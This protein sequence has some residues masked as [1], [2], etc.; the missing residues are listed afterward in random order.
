MPITTSCS[1]GRKLNLKDELAGKTVKCPQCGAAL[2]VPDGKST[3][4][5]VATPPPRSAPAD[6]KI[7]EKPSAPAKKKDDAGPKIVMSNFK[8]LEDF[9]DAGNLKKKKKTFTKEEEAASEVGTSGGEMAK[10][11]AE[12]LTAE[13]NKP[14]HRCP[15]CGKGVKPDDVI[16]IKCGTNIKT[17]RRLGESAF[18]L[19]RR[20]ML[21]VVGI[22]A[23]SAAGAF[24][25][26]TKI[27]PPPPGRA[28]EE[29]VKQEQ[30]EIEDTLA[31]LKEIVED[32][33]A[34][35]SRALAHVANTGADALPVLSAAVRNGSP[36]A[37]RKAV[38]LMEMLAY[39]GYRT[40]ES[41]RALG[42]LARDP[43]TT[44]KEWAAEAL[45]WSAWD[46]PQGQQY[47]PASE[48][49]PGKKT[50]VSKM[51]LLPFNVCRQMLAD[52][53]VAVKKN[54]KIGKI[55]HSDNMP[56]RTAVVPLAGYKLQK[57]YEAETMQSTKLTRLI[58][59]V[60]A[61]RKH[62]IERL[63]WYVEPEP[64]KNLGFTP[65]QVDQERSLRAIREA[66]GRGTRR[67]L[68]LMAWW[69]SNGKNQFPP[70]KD[71]ADWAL[72]TMPEKEA[73]APEKK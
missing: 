9:D 34:D 37:R 26:F 41:V 65:S 51:H 25:H 5:A 31:K 49:D 57:F 42:G 38:K 2:K 15:G 28:N 63:I 35:H 18:T 66:T 60:R 10:I 40:E 52:A 22:L 58:Q 68:D 23:I 69:D 61:G 67:Y 70:P 21:I 46:L 55:D 64:C 29:A 1:C 20:T 11:A 48:G 13:K 6:S 62:L 8:S 39:N 19:S 32:G 59:A 56:R 53:G 71:P 17:G 14:K 73:V 30:G 7:I 50:D 3:A 45:M 47:W 12:A 54:P 33:D 43:D 24:Y 16:C 44:L 72:D 36:G 4:T 27:P